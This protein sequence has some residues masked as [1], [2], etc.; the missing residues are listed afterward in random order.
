MDRRYRWSIFAVLR[1]RNIQLEPFR[2]E[3]RLHNKTI[4]NDFFFLVNNMNIRHNNCD[5]KDLKRYCK[6]FADLSDKEKENLYDEIYQEALMAYLV[7]EQINREKM[8]STLRQKIN[9]DK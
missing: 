1:P 8:I 4:E 9:N 6:V 7:L 3:L 2:E 5:P